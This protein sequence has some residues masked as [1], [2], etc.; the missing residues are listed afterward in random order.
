MSPARLFLTGSAALAL[1]LC[2]T[3]GGGPLSASSRPY[4]P[5]TVSIARADAIAAVRVLSV[6]PPALDQ[7]PGRVESLLLRTFKGS[8]AG[9][10]VTI[11]LEP[12]ERELLYRLSPGSEVVVF[13]APGRTAGDYRLADPTFLPYG[14]PVALRLA[15]AI[16]NVPAWTD[17]SDGLTAIV[18]PDHDPPVAEARDPVRYRVGE[19]IILWAGY[20]NEAR[21]DV[22]LRYRDWPLE[23]HTHW[24]L[25]VERVGA[26]PVGP[27][28]HPH[29]DDAGIR[30]FFSRNT[31]RFEVTLKPAE[32][33]FLYLDRINSAEPGW[34]YKERIGFRYYPMAVPGEY[35]IS[36]VGR[37]LHPGAPIATRVLRVWVE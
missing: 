5:L 37:F 26:G 17:A 28:A 8:A 13:L 36:A 33:F 22:V 12:F 6:P 16:T 4:T 30:D 18:V 10:R 7:R 9:P 34:G 1:A 25:S 29:V 31:H 23:S 27:L 19:P 24:D 14:E 20:R 21:H 11:A 15:K 35:A 3:P 2:V 32:S